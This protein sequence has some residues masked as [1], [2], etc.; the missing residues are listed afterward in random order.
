M[1]SLGYDNL[2]E[3]FFDVFEIK[4]KNLDLVKEKKGDFN[5]NPIIEVDLRIKNEI[6]KNVRFVLTKENGVRIN[7]NL[8]DYTKVAIYENKNK[9]KPPVPITEKREQK[10]IPRPIIQEKRIEKPKPIIVEQSLIEKTKAEFFES[11]RGEVLEE[12]KREVK[13]G[14]IADLIK[15]SLQ[16]NFDSVITDTGS[17]NKLHKILENFNNTF[18]KEYID[19]AEKVSRREALRISEGGGGTNAVQY[20]NGGTMNGDLTVTGNLQSN[21]M[22]VGD[23]NVDTLSVNILSAN[24]EFIIHNLSVSEGITAQNIDVDI[25]KVNTLSTNNE[26]VIHNLSVSEGITAQNIDV[27]TLRV[28]TLSADNEFVIHNLSVTE[29]ISAN[30]V[31]IYDTLSTG[32]SIYS[33]YGEFYDL[34]VNHNLSTKNNAYVYGTLSAEKV[35]IN[36][37]LTTNTISSNYATINHNLSVNENLVTSYETVNN[38]LSV[39]GKLYTNQAAITNNLTVGGG[40][41]SYNGSYVLGDVIITGNLTVSQEIFG[42]LVS[43]NTIVNSNGDTLLAKAVKN[44][45]GSSFV[46][47]NYTVHHNLSS[48][49]LLM[50]L[51]YVNPNGTREVVHASMINDTLSTTQISFGN[52]PPVSDNYKLVIMS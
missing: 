1:N 26:F 2:N 17:R 24:N 32:N 27:D 23:I 44:I 52:Q 8:L 7:P 9:I 4:L 16:S 48:Y 33:N 5:G 47:G 18:R 11:I 50:T 15:E 20:A 25:L 51:Y 14:I 38:D 49:D 10:P 3:I 36:S 28:K 19:L 40:V 37:S 42:D 12:L 22:S 35:E 41:S 13:A 39:L 46:N 34:T 31:L 21:S 45:S 29:G 43:G 30:T 6:F